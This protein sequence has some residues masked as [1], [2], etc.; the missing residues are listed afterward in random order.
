MAKSSKSG[1]KG[2]KKEKK[3]VPHGVAH[4]HATFNS[5]ISGAAPNGLVVMLF[6]IVT[7]GG[8]SL[9]PVRGGVSPL[10][11]FFGPSWLE[12]YPNIPSLGVLLPLADVEGFARQPLNIPAGFG[13]LG[14]IIQA[15]DLT[16]FTLSA[17]CLI[18][19]L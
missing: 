2:G 9:F 14:A 16:T 4:I 5:D 10:G 8:P 13:G 12:Y 18:N 11:T 19:W 3:N 15:G 6:D 7:L 17:P 1:K